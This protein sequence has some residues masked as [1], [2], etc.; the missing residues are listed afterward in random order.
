ML[1]RLTAA[2]TSLYIVAHRE[3][4]K[5]WLLAARWDDGFTP[6]HGIQC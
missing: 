2:I 4:A 1:L 5:R 6:S 3:H